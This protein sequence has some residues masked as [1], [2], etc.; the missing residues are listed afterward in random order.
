MT[1]F[2]QC[3]WWVD[4][5]SPSI[6]LYWLLGRSVLKKGYVNNILCHLVRANHHGLQ[7]YRGLRERFYFAR[8]TRSRARAT[9][10]GMLYIYIKLMHLSVNGARFGNAFILLLHHLFTKNKAVD[11]QNKVADSF[12]H[13]R[14]KFREP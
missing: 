8:I 3:A 12:A 9:V 10:L 4:W 5:E 13:M 6:I 1:L 11:S 14:E 2:Q 7:K